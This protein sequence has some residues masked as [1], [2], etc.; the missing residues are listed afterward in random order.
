MYRSTDASHKEQQTNS[1]IDSING[2]AEESGL[3]NVRKE[4]Y[5]HTRK[6]ID[7]YVKLGNVSVDKDDILLTSIETHGG[8]LLQDH[9][10]LVDMAGFD[11]DRVNF[12]TPAYK[13]IIERADLIVF[14]QSS[15]SAISKL[16]ASFFGHNTRTDLLRSS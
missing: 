7:R 10:Y 11:G 5:V 13:A 2:L 15:N 4:V 14:V 8:K 16:S 12:D 1:I 9:V 6:N 3:A